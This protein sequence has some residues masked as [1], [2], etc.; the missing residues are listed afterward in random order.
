MG[1][2][3]YGGTIYTMK[4]VEETVEAVFVEDGI[5]QDIGEREALINTYMDRI[6]KEYNLEGAIMYPGFVDSH[7]HI[8]GHGEKLLRIDLSTMKSAEEVLEA[9]AR[10]VVELEEDEWL[11]ADGWNENQWNDPRIIHKS[12]LDAI[13]EKHPI[14]L[15][16]ICRHA[17][18]VNSKA[19]ELANITVA[20]E[21]PQGGKIVRDET[22]ESTGYLLDQAQEIVKGIIPPISETRLQQT[23][24]VAVEDLLSLGLVGGHSEDL[25]YYGGFDRTLRAYHQVL[26]AT[27]KFRAH[28][29]VHHLVFE[30]MLA[31]G[32]RYGDGGEYT[33]L[34]AMKLFSDGALG[35]RTAWLSEA[36]ADDPN[37]YGINIHTTEYL[38]KLFQQARK[39]Q[40]PIAVHAI[41]DQAVEEI[42]RCINKYP[43]NN[44]LRD[45]IIHAQIMNEI[46]LEKLTKSTA[47]IDVQPS[48]VA[49]DFPWVKERLGEARANQSY[50]WKTYLDR[51]I[52]CA[53]GSDAP[54]EEVNPL[55]G[56]QAAVTRR[57][58]ID[59]QVYGEE[60]RLSVFEAIGLYTKG[61]AAII[62][63]ED[64]RGLIK[65]GFV[66][67]FTILDQDLFQHD[68][69]LFHE[70]NVKATIVD[71]QVMYERK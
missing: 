40:H 65:N 26:P 14:M 31:Q 3:Y 19:L 29:L 67:D 46:L 20:T 9:L 38:E 71:G 16:R 56:I 4:E 44:G 21:D 27:Y 68:P 48:F 59:G 54:I 2:I 39:Y 49:S 55:L 36:Y 32:L 43:L 6:D 41:G 61:S 66:A 47:M 53:G 60:Q 28:L 30:D 11:I 42:V 35:G 5:I 37:N 24:K 8:I 63:H 10:K 34:G 22:G 64:D 58:N 45:R 18:I 1:T 57:S 12:E 50:P 52:V 33:T 17:I 51:G 69:D 62:N 15:T 13:T 25:A 70:V 7:L 23:V